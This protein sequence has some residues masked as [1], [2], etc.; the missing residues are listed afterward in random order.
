MQDVGSLALGGGG[1]HGLLIG[2]CDKGDEGANTLY[3]RMDE[4]LAMALTGW[5]RK[6]KNVETVF[7]SC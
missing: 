3:Y 1:R 7:I 2:P 6:V 4:R 5:L